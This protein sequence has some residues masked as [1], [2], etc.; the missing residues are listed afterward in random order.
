MMMNQ[1]TRKNNLIE[2]LRIQ[3]FKENIVK[4]FEKVEREEFIPDTY[5]S[6]AYED[7]ALPIGR[8]QTISQPS[9]IAFMLQLLDVQD[10]QK[11]LEVGSGSGY[12]LALLSEMNPSGKIIGTERIS[13]LVQSSREKL[14]KY[15]NVE[16]FYTPHFIGLEE[17]SPFD[18]ILVSASAQEI[19]QELIEQLKTSGIL[20]IPVLNSIMRLEKKQKGSEIEEYE[21]FAFVPLVKD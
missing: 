1:K 10:G 2:S 11:I 3:G 5:R 19:P 13:E 9:T 21:G 8:G 12:V 16:I 6:A 7:M 4:A 18:R 20:V 14:G 15:E 17:H